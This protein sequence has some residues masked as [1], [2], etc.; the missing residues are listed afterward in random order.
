M[1]RPAPDAPPTSPPGDTPDTGSARGV[2]DRPLLRPILKQL[3]L[4]PKRV[5]AVDDQTTWTNARLLGGALHVAKLIRRTTDAPQV[6]VMLPTSGAFG[7]AV[8]GCW[9][10]GRVPVP[11]NYLLTKTDLH[12]VLGDAGIDTLLTAEKMLDYLSENLGPDALPERFNAVPLEKQAF[13]KIPPLRWPPNPRPE[14][15]GVLLYTSGTSG[16][17]KGV[18]LTHGNL[19]SNARAC[20]DYANLDERLV[21]MGVLPQFHTFG[22][23][24]MTLI[25]MLLGAKVVYQARFV[26]RR[27]IQAV[28]EHRVSLLV[29]VPSMY[30]AMLS[31]KSADTDD[32]S[33]LSMT[34]AGGEKLSADLHQRFLDRFKVNILEGYGLTETS[35]VTN[36]SAPHA[37]KL[38]SVGR[39][40]TGVRNVILDDAEQPLPTGV[41]GEIGIVSPAVMR[42]YRGLADLTQEVVRTLQIDG[43]PS[44]VFKTGDIGHVDADGYLFITGR[45]KEMLIVS[46]EN[47]FPRE[48]EE[49]LDRHPQV[50]ASAVIGKPDESRGEVPVAFLEAEASDDDPEPKIDLDSVKALCREQLPPFKVPRDFRQISTL[51]RNPTGKI[52]RRQLQP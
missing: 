2:S 48:I 51:P 46:G 35:P 28:K 23:T 29:A 26:P 8:L 31:V 33:S 30:A 32:L 21:F 42:G 19:A 7:M 10:A 52:L 50:R 47:V 3:L 18:E 38:G 34:I 5:A 49:V 22:L 41:D 13:G 36:W 40:I 12:H 11:L 45:K 1:T 43:R 39:A 27:V 15:L 9:L 14:D 24:V 25:P 17:P 37:Q 44:R 6:G 4:H 16:R 20:I